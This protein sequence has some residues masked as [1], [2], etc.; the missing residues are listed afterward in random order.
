M[1]RAA[2]RLE[3]WLAAPAGAEGGPVLDAVRAALDDDLDTPTAVAA[4]DEAA[5]GGRPV[6]AA[7]GLLG[8]PL[9]TA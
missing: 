4:I 2:A 1:P 3:A 7:A 8:V 6:A 5:G 9:L